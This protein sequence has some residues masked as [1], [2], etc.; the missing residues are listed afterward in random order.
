MSRSFEERRSG[1]QRSP[2]ILTGVTSRSRPGP[3]AVFADVGEADHHGL[4]VATCRVRRSSPAL[5][6]TPGGEHR[7]SDRRCYMGLLPAKLK[8]DVADVRH[9]SA[10]VSFRSHQHVPAGDAALGRGALQLVARFDDGCFRDVL[11]DGGCVVRGY[12]GLAVQE[13]SCSLW[14]LLWRRSVQLAGALVFAA[15]QV[16]EEHT[17][18]PVEVEWRGV[19]AESLGNGVGDD[20]EATPKLVDKAEY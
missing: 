20:G 18:C 10:A 12:S 19:D 14:R 4:H 6:T 3:D 8:G 5:P 9:E 11:V 2:G 15:R 16:V 7:Q 1:C 17:V 13:A